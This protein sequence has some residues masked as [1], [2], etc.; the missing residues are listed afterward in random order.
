MPEAPKLAWRRILLGCAASRLRE[1]N[2]AARPAAPRVLR[3]ERRG[4]DFMVG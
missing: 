1:I 3:K 4:R 2:G